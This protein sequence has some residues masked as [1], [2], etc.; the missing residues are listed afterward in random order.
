MGSTKKAERP[1]KR[2][3]VRWNGKEFEQVYSDCG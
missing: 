3:L 1:T 2:N